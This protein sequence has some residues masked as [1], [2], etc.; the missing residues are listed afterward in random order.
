MCV[1]YAIYGELAHIP[2]QC[3]AIIIVA[4][5]AKNDTE[6]FYTFPQHQ[7]LHST[8]FVENHFLPISRPPPQF[9]KLESG[10]IKK[11]AGECHYRQQFEDFKKNQTIS[12]ND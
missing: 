12:G 7:H 4:S 10:C 6:V 8:I 11:S 5:L 2:D 1:L 9:K 3:H